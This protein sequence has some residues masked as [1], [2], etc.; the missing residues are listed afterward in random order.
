MALSLSVFGNWYIIHL[1]L[2]CFI[3]S[4]IKFHFHA[5]QDNP[6]NSFNATWF[7]ATVDFVENRLEASLHLKGI[8]KFKKK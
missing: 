1:Y 5:T 8:S 4:S 6:I 3:K 7:D 2:I